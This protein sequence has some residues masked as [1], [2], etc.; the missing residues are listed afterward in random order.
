MKA[1]LLAGLFLLTSLF[2]NLNDES[3]TDS[4]AAVENI[5]QNEGSQEQAETA[6]LAKAI[7][8]SYEKVPSRVLKGEIF[9][10]TIKALSTVKDFV[11]ITYELSDSEG[12]KL[13]N[14][15]PSRNIDSNNYFETFYFLA[16]SDTI[17]LPNITATLL[18]DNN[19]RYQKTTL[20]GEKLDVISLNPDKNFSNIIA[21]SFEVTQYKTTNYDSTHNIVV[22]V[23]TAANCNISALKLNDVYKQG[24]ESIFES[25]TNSKI[26]YYAIID[27]SIDNLSFTYFN[28]SKNR[29]IPINIPII[30]NDDMVTTQSDLK[31]KDQSHEILKMGLASVI[32]L[33][34]FLIILWRKKYIY[35]IFIIIPLVYVLYAGTPSKEVCIKQGANIYLLPVRNGTIFETTPSEYHLQKEGESEDWIKIQLENKKIGWVKNEDLCSN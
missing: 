34:A 1:L 23:A 21:D 7:Y 27:K 35:L 31:P 4:S 9:K 28:L 15:F 24:K 6:V 18:D 11:D 22:F 17:K 30:V 20:F 26:T 19:I 2:A 3:N 10:V 16:T 5:V 29:F 13:L 14:D 8:L 32:A 33:V 12:V 25:Y